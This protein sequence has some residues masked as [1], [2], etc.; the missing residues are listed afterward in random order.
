MA[1][2]QVALMAR[3][4]FGLFDACGHDRGARVVHRMCRSA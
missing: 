1:A 4:G 3:L 2:D